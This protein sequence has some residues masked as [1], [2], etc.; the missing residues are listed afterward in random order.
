MEYKKISN[1][2]EN[3]IQIL[4]D[5]LV[6]D[7]VETDDFRYNDI[8][9][10]NNDNF[11][12]LNSKFNMKVYVARL[13]SKIN[14]I[15][16]KYDCDELMQFLDKLVT[17][18][19]NN[20]NESKYNKNKQKKNKNKKTKQNKN[21]NF[22]NKNGDFNKKSSNSDNNVFSDNKRN[23]NNVSPNNYENSY[24]EAQFIID[25]DYYDMNIDSSNII[26]DL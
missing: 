4:D 8:F 7:L 12:G 5:M 2:L 17:F 6:H 18:I 24:V 11:K 1:E 19:E 23:L 14:P 22:N 25:L 16:L 9:N 15:K 21:S 13:K 26:I 10:L 20:I 3:I